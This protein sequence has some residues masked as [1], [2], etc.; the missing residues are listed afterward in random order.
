VKRER[1]WL[2]R[3]VF[4]G[5]CLVVAGIVIGLIVIISTS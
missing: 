5:A 4:V 1:G 2:L 3:I